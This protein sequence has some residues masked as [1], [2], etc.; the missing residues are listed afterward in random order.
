M[1][2]VL[3]VKNLKVIFRTGETFV[4]AVEGVDIRIGEGERVAIVGESGCGKSVT[5]LA[6]MRLLTTPP[7]YIAALSPFVRQVSSLV[8]Y[9]LL[10]YGQ[11]LCLYPLANEHYRICF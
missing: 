11:S 10:Q 5:S 4:R 3:N 8:Y 7:A 2:D 6:C 1:A 9:A